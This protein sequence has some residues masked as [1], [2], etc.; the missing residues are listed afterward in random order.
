MDG[1]T[2]LRRD[3]STLTPAAWRGVV[4]RC[5]PPKPSEGDIAVTPATAELGTFDTAPG[6]LRGQRERP[7]GGLR[8]E[9]GVSRRL[10]GGR[11][12]GEDRSR[13]AVERIN[14]KRRVSASAP[15]TPNTRLD[16]H[17]VFL[18]P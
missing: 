9:P 13:R 14:S 1:F 8:S 16:F 3:W 4:S 5:F 6:G 17:R 7:R 11:F 15:V 2:A 10:P 12:V 18:L